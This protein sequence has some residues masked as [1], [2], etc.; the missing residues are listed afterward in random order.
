[1]KDGGFWRV[2]LFVILPYMSMVV[3]VLGHVWRYR[4]DQFGWTSQSSQLYER[5]L[6]LLGSPLFHY[7]TVLAIL[8]HALGLLIPASWTNAIGLSEHPYSILSHTAGSLAAVLVLAGLIVLTVRRAARDRVR[9]AT[10]ALDVVAFTMLWAMIVLGSYLS[11]GVGLAGGGYDYRPTVSAWLRSLFF[12]HPNLDNL[13]GV[14]TLYLVHA[15]LAWVYLALFPFTRFVHFWSIPVWYLTRPFVVYR[16]RRK[17]A[18]LSPGESDA[19][20]TIGDRPRGES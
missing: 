3:F 11:I 4:S 18:V 15:S 1:M 19:W 10:T 5:N 20:K 7:G 9:Q 17:E 8:G 2:L 6:L 13:D 16:R 12:F 14:P